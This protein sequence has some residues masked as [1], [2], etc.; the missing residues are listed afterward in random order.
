MMYHNTIDIDNSDKFNLASIIYKI[1]RNPCCLKLEFKP[2]DSKGFHILIICSKKCEDCRIVFDDVRRLEMDMKREEKFKNVLFT[3]KEY[4]KGSGFMPNDELM[5]KKEPKEPKK[6]IC[7]RCLK[8]GKTSYLDKETLTFQQVKE[9]IQ[10]GKI[11][12]VYP[13]KLVFLHYDYFICSSC[14]WFKFVKCEV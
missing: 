13:A 11:P 1:E 4:F 2:S 6:H 12:K 7:D 14:N 9:K 8:F 5:T 10:I 3:E